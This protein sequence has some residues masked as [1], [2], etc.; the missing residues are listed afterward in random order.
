MSETLETDQL[1]S[2]IQLKRKSEIVESVPLR[3]SST[4]HYSK[5]WEHLFFDEA[6]TQILHNRQENRSRI[7]RVEVEGSSETQKRGQSIMHLKQ[8]KS[9]N[10]YLPGTLVILSPTE[11]P[12]A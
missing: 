12:F 2:T 11:V 5:L 4:E 6:K 9:G 10:Q 1:I 7:D 8:I 3:F